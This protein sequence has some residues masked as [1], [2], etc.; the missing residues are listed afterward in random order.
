MKVITM[1]YT[2]QKFCSGQMGGFGP[3]NGAHPHSSKSTQ[4]FFIKIL[5]NE[6][7]W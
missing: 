3:K 5:Q 2:K 7:G 6:R 4:S 1:V